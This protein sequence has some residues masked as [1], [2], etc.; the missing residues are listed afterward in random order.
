M[1]LSQQLCLVTFYKPKYRPLSSTLAVAPKAHW[2][3]Y[4]SGS[5]NIVLLEEMVKKVKVGIGKGW[6][7]RK[8]VRR[9]FTSGKRISENP[10]KE[11]RIS[12]WRQS[13]SG[14]YVNPNPASLWVVILLT[15]VSTC[16]VIHWTYQLNCNWWS[17]KNSSRMAWKMILTTG[18]V[19]LPISATCLHPTSSTIASSRLSSAFFPK[20]IVKSKYNSQQPV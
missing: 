11:C 20:S 10:Q 9:D 4:F 1:E 3:N 5:P 6:K 14:W 15:F 8:I 13:G 17:S 2:C 12:D 19:H 16:I 18:V 7:N